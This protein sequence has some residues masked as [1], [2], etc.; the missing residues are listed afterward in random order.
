MDGL[1][2]MV[3]LFLR[4]HED[5]K[6]QIETLQRMAKMS[7]VLPK[8]VDSEIVTAYCSQRADL[9]SYHRM[10]TLW[11]DSQ[12]DPAFKDALDLWLNV[13]NE[14]EANS[15]TVLSIITSALDE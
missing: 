9:I 11:R 3:P 14:I 5:T 7:G 2:H 8:I 15:K 10:L 12:P 6:K 13:L 1:P 4:M